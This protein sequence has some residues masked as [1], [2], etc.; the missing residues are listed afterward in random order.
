MDTE[1]PSHDDSAT[2]ENDPILCPLCWTPFPRA[3]RKR[4][5]SDHCRKTAW[6]RTHQSIPR[7]VAP[8][9]PPRRRR[10][11]TVYE[12]PHCENRY[13]AQQWC[14]DCGRPCNRIGYGGL[15]PN[16]DEPVAATDLFDTQ[17]ETQKC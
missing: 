4:Y 5:C 9:P 7:P 13:F 8:V 10:D 14:Y 16:C 2:I 11:N 3:G 15:C 17:P 6:A 12:C 1:T